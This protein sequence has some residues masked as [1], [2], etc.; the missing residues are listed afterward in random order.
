MT[1]Q[2]TGKFDV[3]RSL[4]RTFKAAGGG[5]GVVRVTGIHFFDLLP[6]VSSAFKDAS[7]HRTRLLRFGLGLELEKGLSLLLV[8][9][10]G[11]DGPFFFKIFFSDVFDSLRRASTLSPHLRLR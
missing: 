1:L 10:R 11:D 2:G 7:H 3:P 5:L 8:R 4:S 6:S 9:A